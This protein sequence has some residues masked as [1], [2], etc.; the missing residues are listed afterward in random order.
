M[1]ARLGGEGLGSASFQFYLA[2]LK[3]LTTLREQRDVAQQKAKS[4]T[5]SATYQSLQL[6]EPH[7]NPTVQQL[8]QEASVVHTELNKVVNII[9]YIVKIL[10]P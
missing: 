8:R 3:C 4:L 5:Q 9:Y 10:H 6:P 7:L 1:A 2:A